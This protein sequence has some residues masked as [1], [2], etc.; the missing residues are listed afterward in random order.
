MCEVDNRCIYDYNWLSRIGVGPKS[1]I[2]V[3]LLPGGKRCSVKWFLDI[4]DIPDQRRKVTKEEKARLDA[5]KAA[6]A[7][8][9]KKKK[10]K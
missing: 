10:K 6:A 4:E 7:A 5:E 3:Q 2:H 1:F 9:S 8:A